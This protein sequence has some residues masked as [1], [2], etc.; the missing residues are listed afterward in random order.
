M[1]KQH[2]FL[3]V[4]KE[5][6][7]RWQVQRAPHYAAETW[8]Q[9]ER[10]ALPWLGKMP[11]HKISAPLVLDVLRRI[12]ARGVSMPVIKVR[13]HIG[14]IFRYAIACGY[15][16][17][18]PARD[19]GYALIPHKT[20]PYATILDPKQIGLLMR[21]IN[22]MRFRQRRHALLMVAYTFVRAGE[23]ASA[24]WNE[25]QWDDK[26]WRIPGHKMKM[27]RPHDVPLSR[28]ALWVL[29][30]QHNLSG[31]GRWVWPCRWDKSKHEQGASLR[32][33]L[34]RMGYG[35]GE[36]T[37]HGFRAMAATTLLELG[38]PSDVIERQLAHVDSNR[39]RAAYQRSTLL[40]E[41]SR[42]M[43][44]WADWLDV[45]TAAAILGR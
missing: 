10:E 15:A 6:Y 30:E 8:R 2:C 26:L 3:E 9:L 24:E 45:R 29:R 42:M 28:Q 22:E 40:D 43:Q 13:G 1:A 18:N 33:A 34:R 44:A 17:S 16:L 21:Q 36:M 19:L 14:Q 38:W 7:A 31:S 37:T 5:W 27:K 35:K 11:I 25:I 32:H 39:T 41:R 4:A 12:E 23:L 20:T